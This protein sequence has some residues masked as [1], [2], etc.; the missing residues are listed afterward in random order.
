MRA[1]AISLNSVDFVE[2]GVKANPDYKGSA[3][4]FDFEGVEFYCK[5]TVGQHPKGENGLRW[6]VGL[7]F[8]I[9]P[10]DDK[11]TPYLINV[12]VIGDFGINE[13]ISVDKREKMV[14]ESGTALVYGAVREMVTTITARSVMG[15]LVLPTASF[16]GE[17]EEFKR[18]EEQAAKEASSTPVAIEEKK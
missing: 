13:A 4:D 12:R 17:F 8:A 11:P 10:T 3:G 1:S 9:R 6:W 2:I 5:P 7:K 14:F 18:K 15:A 16:F